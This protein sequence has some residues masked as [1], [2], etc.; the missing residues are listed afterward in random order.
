MKAIQLIRIWDSRTAKIRTH[1]FLRKEILIGADRSSHLRLKDVRGFEAKIN[2]DTQTIR[3]LDQSDVEKLELGGIFQLGP[4][5]LHWRSFKFAEYSSRRRLIGM[6]LLLTFFLGS[7]IWLQFRESPQCPAIGK[8]SINFE[9]AL[10]EEIYVKA[11]VELNQLKQD[12]LSLTKSAACAEG[13]EAKKLEARFWTAVLQQSLDLKD[14]NAVAQNFL[15]LK[16]LSLKDRR[17]QLLERR[18][19]DLAREVYLDG[20]RAE[21]QDFEKGLELMEKAREICRAIHLPPDC[22]KG[23]SSKKNANI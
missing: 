22:F 20:Y 17:E 13:V 5:A 1:F 11:R 15:E 18:V 21:D 8:I 12:Y 9:R 3:R 7:L 10:R 19:I 16:K 4:Y 14:A 2:F 6:I 23:A